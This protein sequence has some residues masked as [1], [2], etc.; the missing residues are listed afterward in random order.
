MFYGSGAGKL[1]TASAVVADMVEMARHAD[2]NIYICWEQEK[3]ELADA[4][5]VSGRFF[6]RTT[7]SKEKVLE[8]F[9]AVEM[10]D[11]GLCDEIG[12]IT[13]GMKEK[14]YKK[15]AELLGS[16]LQMIRLA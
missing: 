14:D 11:A 16:V 5:E 15:K 7:E 3:M 1:P 10:I 9:D 6:V 12:F 13:G 4:D 2:E 8:V